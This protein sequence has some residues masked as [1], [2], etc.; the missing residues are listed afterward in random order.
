MAVA[1][2]VTPSSGYD[3]ES[4]FR[5]D[6]TGLDDTDP[7]SFDANQTPREDIY[8]YYIEMS[9]GG[10]IKGKSHVFTPDS[11]DGA[12]SWLNVTIPD[13]GTYVFSVKR[14]SDDV[15]VGSVSVSVS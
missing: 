9:E 13:A 6:V 2:S 14:V 3:V 7:T 5:V 10:T 12:H 15:T 8:T 11:V 4:T 1:V